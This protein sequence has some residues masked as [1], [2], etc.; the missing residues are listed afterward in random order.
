MNA[1]TLSPINELLDRRP[2]AAPAASSGTEQGRQE[3]KDRSGRSSS[4]KPLFTSVIAKIFTKSPVSDKQFEGKSRPPRSS[5][6]SGRES[7]R[8]STPARSAE[9][10]PDEILDRLIAEN[11]AEPKTE[12]LH[13]LDDRLRV[14]GQYE[15]AGSSNALRA[16]APKSGR[17]TRDSSQH[18]GVNHE[19]MVDS[20]ETEE[21]QMLLR[22]IG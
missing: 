20:G 8:G 2:L 10:D 3:K 14:I 17:G 15:E 16:T 21:Q 22:G 11:G 9:L 7:A 1:P 12:P 5:R 6:G 19:N 4:S 13:L 18:R